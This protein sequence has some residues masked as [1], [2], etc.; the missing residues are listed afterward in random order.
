MKRRILEKVVALLL[1]GLWSF[2]A[3]SQITPERL[4]QFISDTKLIDKTGIRHT[5]RVK[6]FYTRLNYQTAWLPEKNQPNLTIFLRAKNLS[7][8]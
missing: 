6:E 7:G 8:E 4:R 3:F 2:A 1:A 5:S